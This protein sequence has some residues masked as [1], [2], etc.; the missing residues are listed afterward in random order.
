MAKKRLPIPLL[1]LGGLCLV[2]SLWG[3]WLF[4]MK[5]EWEADPEKIP[6][7]GVFGDSFGSLNTLFAG[8]AFVGVIVTLYKQHADGMEADERHDETLQAQERIAKLQALSTCFEFS[9]KKV[10][11]CEAAIQS[12]KQ[13]EF[14][15]EWLLSDRANSEDDFI[16]LAT[17]HL[18]K[19]GPEFAK[20][21]S[22]HFGSLKGKATRDVYRTIQEGIPTLTRGRC[23]LRDYHSATLERLYKEIAATTSLQGLAV[24]KPR[25][26][27]TN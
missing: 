15:F 1:F 17:T 8:L 24:S 14:Y 12:L 25:R 21:A 10:A 9:S 6:K 2:G 22:L 3:G 4:H 16:A 23:E 20:L 19:K 5:K 13:L 18:S 11:E 26:R 7:L 27:H